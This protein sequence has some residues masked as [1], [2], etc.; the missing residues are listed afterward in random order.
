M[1]PQSY[2]SFAEELLR[3]CLINDPWVEGR[4]RFRIDPVV[5]GATAYERLMRSAEG[6]GR[7][8]EELARIVL[9]EPQ[10]LDTF[11]HL[12]P[13]QK[14]M[15][16]AS[17]GRWHGIAR[18]D[19]FVLNDGSIRMCEMNSD[20]P[21]GEA[22]AVL[23]N[24]LALRDRSAL[25][26]PNADLERAFCSMVSSCHLAGIRRGTG[27]PQRIGIVYPTE[28]T[29]DLS[30]I[31]LYEQWFERR[32]WPVGLGSPF[33]LLRTHGTLTLMGEPVD[34]ILRHY[35]TDWWG[36]R[37][38]AWTDEEEFADPDPLTGPLAAVL[39]SELDR[40]AVVI[41]PFGTVLTQNKLAMAFF[42]RFPEKFSPA[43]QRAI[44]SFI[45]ETYRLE[46]LVSTP[47]RTNWVLKSDYG[48]EGDEVVVGPW[49]SDDVWRESLEKAVPGR[50]VVQRFFEAKALEGSDLLPNFGVFLIGGRGAGVYTRLSSQATDCL[51]LTAATLVDHP[52]DAG[53]H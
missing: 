9:R 11:F 39:Q 47:D 29:E 50:W 48:C 6:I 40:S 20:T 33:N 2:V 4:E 7:V 12:T 31:S 16:L 13:Y 35:K 44:R 14:L 51:S 32:G 28:M 21:S 42:W 26:D 52:A 43:A 25:R 17:E 3:S 24:R 8:Y 10:W 23:L 45:P 49:V 37:Y 46:D 22:E 19:L 15:W 27:R 18:L 5:L 36:E 1:I 41:N 34:V 30:M 53:T 38:P